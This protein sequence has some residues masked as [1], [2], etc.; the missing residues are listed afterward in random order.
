MLYIDASLMEGGNEDGWELNEDMELCEE[1]KKKKEKKS[2]KEHAMAF[3][4]FKIVR[5][6]GMC[7]MN[8]G[9]CLCFR[10]FLDKFYFS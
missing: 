8:M 3:K 7:K 9:S 6:I 4:T 10:V 5:Q 2:G 1:E